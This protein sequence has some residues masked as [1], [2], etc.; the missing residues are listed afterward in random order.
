MFLSYADSSYFIYVDLC[1]SV[2]EKEL[3][4]RIQIL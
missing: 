1:V 2:I 4:E 3:E